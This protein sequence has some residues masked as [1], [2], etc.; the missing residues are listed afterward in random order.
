MKKI[1]EERYYNMSKKIE[2]N[3]AEIIMITLITMIWVLG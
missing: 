3:M 1:I 2:R